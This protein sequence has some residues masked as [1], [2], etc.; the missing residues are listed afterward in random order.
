VTTILKDKIIVLDSSALIAGLDPFSIEGDECTVPEVEKELSPT[1]MAKTRFK[2]AVEY[3]KLK[4][5][6]PE[7]KFIESVKRV[8]SELGDIKFLSH[9][10]ILILALALKLK[11]EGLNP[12]IATDDYSIQNVADKLGIKYASLATFGIKKLLYWVLYCP[13]CKRNYP[14]NY[15]SMTCEVCGTELKRK[16][17]KE[18]KRGK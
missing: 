16:A 9:V 1:S 12:I 11:K 4:L 17:L 3:G 14:P 5:I 15:N 18:N 7:E 2:A 13:A 10:D 6:T 8:S